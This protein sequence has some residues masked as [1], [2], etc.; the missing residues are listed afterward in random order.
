M[1]D[2]GEEIEEATA[3][4]AS[5]NEAK[6]LH[7]LRDAVD[8]THDPGL[9]REIH[10]LAAMAHESSSGFHKIEWHKLMIETEPQTT[11]VPST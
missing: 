4:L 1:S 10:E 6:A 5:H 2:L 3:L 8:A 7:V 11:G 9:L